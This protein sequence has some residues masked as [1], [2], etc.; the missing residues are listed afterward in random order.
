MT[1]QLPLED[2]GIQETEDQICLANSRSLRFVSTEVEE[3]RSGSKDIW[4]R[5]LKID[6]SGA[7]YG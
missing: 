1:L 5:A 6:S 2:A 4:C 7:Y 3:K